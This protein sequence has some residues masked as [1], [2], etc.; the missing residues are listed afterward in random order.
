[1]GV[2][3]LLISYRIEDRLISINPLH[4]FLGSCREGGGNTGRWRRFR[5][6]CLRRDPRH[7]RD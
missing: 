2:A 7:G 3:A 5:R 6:P 4:R 1:M